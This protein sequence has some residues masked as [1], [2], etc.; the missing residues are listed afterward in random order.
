MNLFYK[1]YKSY[2]L[3][4]HGAVQKNTEKTVLARHV[5]KG[6]AGKEIGQ[7]HVDFLTIGTIFI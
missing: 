7:Y 2:C 4:I 6:K 3:F 1:E 5:D